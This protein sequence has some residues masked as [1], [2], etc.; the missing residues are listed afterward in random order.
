MDD[1]SLLDLL[2]K[3]FESPRSLNSETGGDVLFLCLH[4]MSLPRIV[5]SLNF[6]PW[7]VHFIASHPSLHLLLFCV[8]PHPSCSSYS[9]CSSPTHLLPSCSF[10]HPMRSSSKNSWRIM[11]G[12][13]DE[14]ERKNPVNQRCRRTSLLQYRL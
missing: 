1:Y 13:A 7:V 12:E 4:C 3:T 10:L 8:P 9:S 6:N 2:S 5:V 11:A 14:E